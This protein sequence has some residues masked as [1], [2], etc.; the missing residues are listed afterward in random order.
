MLVWLTMLRL[1]AT[2]DND[3]FLYRLQRNSVEVLSGTDQVEVAERM[4]QLGVENPLRLIEAA[5]TWG[6]VEIREPAH[7]WHGEGI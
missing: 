5:Q 2:F 3:R 7:P 1:T 6:V 4:V